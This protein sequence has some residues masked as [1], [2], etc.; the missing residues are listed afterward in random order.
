VL[1]A[2][3]HALLRLLRTRG[4][5]PAAE[6]VV[7]AFSATGEHGLAWYALAGAGAALDAGRRP[8]YLRALGT[9]AAAYLANQAVKLVV[10][11][12]RPRLQGLPPLTGTVSELSYPSAH[13]STSFAA[14]RTLSG[15]LPA[16]PLYA[17]AALMALSRP[18]LGVHYPS[19]AIAGAALG[20]AV[21][22]LV[23]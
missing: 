21:A 4:H 19:D 11:R 3:D 9:V 14:A 23:P 18:Y 20:E 6:A 12:R 13:A 2:V 17:A 7:R 16:Q 10:R 8:L 5:T 22:R 15:V 1:R